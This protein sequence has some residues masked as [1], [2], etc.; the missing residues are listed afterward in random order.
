MKKVGITTLYHKTINYGGALQAYA[1]QKKIE[2]F[3]CECTVIDCYSTA[4][5]NKYERF[6]ALGLK[7]SIQVFGMKTV[8]KVGI[9]L[10]QIMRDGMN[11]RHKLFSEFLNDIPHT[12]PVDI[13]NIYDLQ[14]KFDICVTGSDQVW[15]PGIWNDAYL[16]RFARKKVSYAASVGAT[17]FTNDQAEELSEALRGY[18]AISVRE[19]GAVQLIQ[20]LT[21][22]K[23]QKVLDPTLLYTAQDWEKLVCPVEV[24][25]PYVFMYAIDNH[26]AFRRAVYKYCQSR[27]IELIT[28]P[29]N[30]SHF[31]I[32]DI[33]YTD[34]PLYAVGPRQWLWLIKNAEMVFTDSFHGSAFCLQ[35][36]KDFWSFEAPCD[37]GTAPD[38]KRIFSL[39]SEFGLE[40]RIVDFDDF[41]EMDSIEKRIDY[42][43]VGVKLNE[44]RKESQDFLMR[45]LKV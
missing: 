4:G 7:R 2:E 3:G 35:F 38:T 22:V 21:S 40:D 29:F 45:A 41:P 13:K 26:P 23:I 1:L 42:W 31:K 20:N 30:Q 33:C 44:L 43:D 8:Y 32:S 6:K 10:D 16:L 9:K 14:D 24:T 39:L 37:E 19:K 34:K 5:K 36:K 27:K 28:I 18:S 15:H 11:E 17:E 25:K 12:E